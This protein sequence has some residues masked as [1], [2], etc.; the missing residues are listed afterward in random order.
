[1]IVAHA[2]IGGESAAWLPTS[3]EIKIQNQKRHVMIHRWKDALYGRVPLYENEHLPHNRGTIR[4]LGA[5]T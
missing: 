5:H 3:T 1:M 4:E 2:D